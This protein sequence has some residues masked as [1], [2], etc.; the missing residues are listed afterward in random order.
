MWMCFETSEVVELGHRC[1]LK[2]CLQGSFCLTNIPCITLFTFDLIHWSHHILFTGGILH[3]TNN[4]HSVFVGLKYVGMPYFPKSHL[5]CSENPFMYGITTGIFFD[6]SFSDIS[7]VSP[8]VSTSFSESLL[9]SSFK[10]PQ[11]PFWVTI[12]FQC[13][14]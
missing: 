10:I 13:L 9:F 14:S 7:I 11:N 4:C 8:H 1:S 2:P 12:A 3:F 5:I 6:L